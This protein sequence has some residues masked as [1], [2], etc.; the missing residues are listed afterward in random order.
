MDWTSST[1]RY[2]GIALTTALGATLLSVGSVA[3]VNPETLAVSGQSESTI[4]LAIA[5]ATAAFGT[6]LNPDG[7]ASNAEGLLVEAVTAGACYDWPSNLTV[8]SNV[9]YDVEVASD[10]TNGNLD[11]V[12]S[13]PTTYVACTSGDAIVNPGVFDAF[14]NQAITASTVHNYWLGLGVKWS[15][16]VSASLGTASLTITA[17][18]NV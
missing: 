7:Q 5:D 17:V 9:I 6:N 18:S 12:G 3:A 2:L 1:R 13:D 10:V 4:T 11:W 15:D 16:G 14:T 8:N